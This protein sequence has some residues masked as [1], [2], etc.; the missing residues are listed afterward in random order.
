M[1]REMWSGRTSSAHVES[2]W[3]IRLAKTGLQALR[4]TLTFVSGFSFKGFDASRHSVVI[5]EAFVSPWKTDR[6]FVETYSKIQGFTTVDM[7]RCYELWHLL[8]QVINLGGDVL[9]VG[10][11]RGGTGCLLAAK[12]QSLNRNAT[13]FL[14]DTFSGVVKAGEIDNFYKGGEHA[15]TSKALVAGLASKL[16][17]DKVRILEGIFP[18]ETGRIIEGNKIC[19]C[20]IDVDVYQSAKDVVNWV[21]PRLQ[22]GGVIVF[23]DYGFHH[24]Q[25]ITQLVDELATKSDNLMLNNLNGHAVLIRRA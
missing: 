3:K 18:D 14:C 25:G 7:Y 13:V 22:V 11:W 17:L 2:V 8:G 15:D 5:P 6:S 12:A 10:V 23:D 19:F 1:E 20:H 9:E 24:C 4:S 21:W 16:C